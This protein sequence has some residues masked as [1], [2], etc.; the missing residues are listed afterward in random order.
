MTV[1]FDMF[2]PLVDVVWRRL[3]LDLPKDLPGFLAR[4]EPNDQGRAYSFQAAATSGSLERLKVRSR[5]GWSSCAV[6]M[7]CTERKETVVCRAIARP[8]Q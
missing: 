2:R 1:R 8:V 3:L 7:R 5:C 6:Q 4:F